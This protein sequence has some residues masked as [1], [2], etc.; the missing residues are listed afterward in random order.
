MNP[1]PK[2]CKGTGKAIGQGCGTLQTIH[3]FGLCL[4]CFKAWLFGTSEGKKFLESTQI[5]AKKQVQTE[6]RKAFNKKKEE[7]RSKSYFE[8]QLQTEINTIVRLIDTDKGCISCSH[9]WGSP[10]TRQAHAGHRISVG[11]NPT[12]RYNVFNIFKQC[13]I[14]NSILSANEREYDKG[15]V[16]IYGL[17]ML[18]Y[19]KTIPAHF[20]S[21]HLSV[22]ELKESISTARKIIKEIQ[23]GKDFTRDEINQKIGI[24][25]ELVYA[26]NH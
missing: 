13:S 12:L 8:K 9:G 10:F 14:C 1:K 5:R 18:E 23:S 7:I 2:R 4:A 19:V 17:E 20:Q 3:K 26:N 15:I 16:R 21:L 24:Y 6:S 22:E 11:S 25:S